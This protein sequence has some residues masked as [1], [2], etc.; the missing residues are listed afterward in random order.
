MVRVEKAPRGQSVTGEAEEHLEENQLFVSGCVSVLE[1]VLS[2]C[3]LQ[4]KERKHLMLLP[5]VDPATFFVN[6]SFFVSK[7]HNIFIHA[8][9]DR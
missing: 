1:S 9:D 5:D 8:S 6:F 2:H 7:F 3:H 4:C